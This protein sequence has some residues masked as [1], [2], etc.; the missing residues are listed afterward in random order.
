MKTDPTQGTN[1]LLV[2]VFVQEEINFVS[3]YYKKSIHIHLWINKSFNSLR[4]VYM[5]REPIRV[6]QEHTEL[7]RLTMLKWE[8]LQRSSKDWTGHTSLMLIHL[9]NLACAS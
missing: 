2:L 8:A 6:F 9:A 1:E 3:N 5:S 4:N 7:T